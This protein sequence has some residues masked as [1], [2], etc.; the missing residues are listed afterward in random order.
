MCHPHA[1]PGPAAKAP[2]TDHERT[3]RPATL[4]VAPAGFGKT[5][6][7]SS[8]IAVR[9]IP[10]AWSSLDSDDNH[11]ARFLTYLIAALAEADTTIVREFR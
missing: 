8:C 10:V 7:V 1:Q 11:V 5:T 4:V 3:R 2:A 6:L 9:R